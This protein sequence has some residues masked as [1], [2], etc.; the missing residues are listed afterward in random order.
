MARRVSPKSIDKELFLDGT[1]EEVAETEGFNAY[2][3][4]KEQPEEEPQDAVVEEKE[5][6]K[7]RKEEEEA[8][9]E[10]LKTYLAQAFSRADAERTGQRSDFQGRGS[11]RFAA[12]Q[13]DKSQNERKECAGQENINRKRA[14]GTAGGPADAGAAAIT[15]AGVAAVG[16]AVAQQVA[17]MAGG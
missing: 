17:A 3:E 6:D 2:V 8:S 13:K 9:A 7:R 11:L 5:K 15:R 12:T 14:E 4:E 10:R 1:V 16:E